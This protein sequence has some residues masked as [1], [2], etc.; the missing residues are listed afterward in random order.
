[1]KVCNYDLITSFHNSQRFS[2][3]EIANFV[4]SVVNDTLT[5]LYTKLTLNLLV[6]LQFIIIQFRVYK[7]IIT[8]TKIYTEFHIQKSTEFRRIK[9]SEL[10]QNSM[11][12]RGIDV[13]SA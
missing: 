13:T 9:H 2:I 6:Y 1:M 4:Y 3:F 12:F 7:K 11:G 5:R 8:D 10:P